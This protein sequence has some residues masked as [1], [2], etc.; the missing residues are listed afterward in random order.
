MRSSDSF[1]VNEKLKPFMPVA[2][3]DVF[4]VNLLPVLVGLVRD[5]QDVVKHFSANLSVLLL[6]RFVLLLPHFDITMHLLLDQASSMLL[7]GM[8]DLTLFF[9]SDEDVHFSSFLVLVLTK[10][11]I[12]DDHILALG[13][14]PDFVLKLLFLG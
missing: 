3:V 2:R 7:L 12:L 1:L 9:F 8:Q 6:L 14:A 13:R 5:V 11:A 4:G 10:I